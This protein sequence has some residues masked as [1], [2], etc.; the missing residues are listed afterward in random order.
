MDGSVPEARPQNGVGTA[1]LVLG[2]L[3]VPLAFVPVLYLV[4]AVPCGG[5]AVVLG[6]RAR[7][8]AAEGRATNEESAR[9]GLWLGAVGLVL[10]LANLALGAFFAVSTAG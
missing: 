9:W 8:L 5:A 7:R 6:R 3:S 10:A 4:A 1:A 2:I